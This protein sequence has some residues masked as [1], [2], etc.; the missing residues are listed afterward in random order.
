LE[1][2]EITLEVYFK[3]GKEKSILYED[4][5]DGYDY[6][7]GRFSLS[8]F[9]LKGSEN[10]LVIQQFK[11]GKF[12]ANYSKYRINL[13]ALPFKVKR[14]Y[15]DNE[16]ADFEPLGFDGKTLLIDKDFTELHITAE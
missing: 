14:I 11:E 5:Q 1:F 9:R 3:S 10:N 13:H 12:E 4:A 2:D 7:K 8:T 6:N 15:I 16:R